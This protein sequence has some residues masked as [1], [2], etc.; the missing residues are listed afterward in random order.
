MRVATIG[1]RLAAHLL[2]T[3]IVAAGLKHAYYPAPAT[4]TEGPAA[5]IFAGAGNVPAWSE[6][7][8][9]HEIR[10]QLMTPARAFPVQELNALE[11]LIEP[12]WD[13]FAPGTNASRLIATGEEGWV[14]YCYP[15]RYEGS[16]VIDYGTGAQYAAV[17]VI[18]DV[19]T[20]RFAG[21]A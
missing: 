18:F 14:E 11:R 8:W 5:V 20:H 16:Q 6:Q 3:D 21:A 17:T 9:H 15:V 7:I 4:I 10:V 19:K 13:V 1:N 2:H 12:I